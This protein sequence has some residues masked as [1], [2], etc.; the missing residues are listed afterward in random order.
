MQTIKYDDLY[1]DTDTDTGE[2]IFYLDEALLSPFTG[3]VVDYFHNVLSWEFEVQDGFR[4]GIERKYYDDTG[5]LME[6][7]E[8]NHNTL[9]GLVKEFYKCGNLK[10]QAMVIRNIFIYTI[11]YDEKQGVHKTE[12]ISESDI[13]YQLVKEHIK[14]YE[15]RYQDFMKQFYNAKG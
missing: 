14:S 13:H 12:T 9:D 8:T 5:E 3:K 6:E 15:E 10:S 4:T 7:N 11:F 1:T 2:D